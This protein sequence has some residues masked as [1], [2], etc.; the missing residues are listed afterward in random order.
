MS[1]LNSMHSR[2]IDYYWLSK[3]IPQL[4]L[5]TMAG[6]LYCAC[7]GARTGQ[8]FL[9]VVERWLF[10]GGFNK[11]KVYGIGVWLGRKILAHFVERWLLVEVWL[12]VFV[13]VLRL[14]SCI[15]DFNQSEQ[16]LCLLNQSRTKPKPIV[17]WVTRV[18]PRLARSDVFPRLAPVVIGWFWFEDSQ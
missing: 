6:P 15:T 12:Y 5:S 8:N 1:A 13:L 11:S 3:G 17:I 16:T 14:L 2:A 7:V 18:F 4:N 10:Y 9:A